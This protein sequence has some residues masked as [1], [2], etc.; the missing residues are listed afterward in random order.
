MNQGLRFKEAR[1]FLRLSQAQAADLVGISQYTIS[2]LESNKTEKPNL[3]YLLHLIKNNIS[4]SWLLEGI[5]EM[6]N[7]NKVFED[8]KKIELLTIEK[9]EDE[10]QLLKKENKSLRQEL[11]DLKDKFIS[12]QMEVF[13]MRKDMS[14]GKDN[15]YSFDG[16][17]S[18]KSAKV[19]YL[20]SEKGT[21]EGTQKLAHC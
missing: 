17:G 13:Q 1:E 2:K 11:S 6:V 9:L 7:K 15:A 5:G 19:I 3:K 21:N 8:S 16:L 20:H 18:F 4:E 10:N 12:F 14:L